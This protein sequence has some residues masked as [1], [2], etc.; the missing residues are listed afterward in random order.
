MK[1]VLVNKFYYPRG[2]DCIHV[3]QLKK[4]LEKNG[5][6]VY[7]FSMDYKQNIKLVED[8][9][10]PTF[11]DFSANSFNSIVKKVIRPFG[12]SE[13]IKKWKYFITHFKPD[14]VHLHNIHSQISPIVAKISIEKKI[15]V[16]WTLHDYKLIC[17]SYLMLRNNRPCD[18]CIT[19]QFSVVKNRCIKNNFAASL[20]GFF[21]IKKWNKRKLQ[22][23]TS[24]FIAP[25]VFLKNQ[26]VKGGFRESSIMHLCNFYPEEKVIPFTKK[27]IDDFILYVG[28]IS[29]EKG[30]ELLLRAMQQFP[31]KKLKI[32]GDGPICSLLKDTYS[33]SRNVEFL[34]FQSWEIIQEQ[35]STARFL[36]VPSEWYENNPLSVIEAL[37]LGTPILGAKIGGIPELISEGKNGFCF[38]PGNLEDLVSGINKM[39]FSSFDRAKISFDAQE[40]FSSERYYEKI[41]QV[42]KQAINRVK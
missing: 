13:V 22:D 36:V 30:V 34:G 25:S 10:W 21:E 19:N 27:K 12:A 17:P 40:K 14:V 2:G 15:P 1:I 28:R 33:D 20:L 16:V 39:F 18:L 38:K 9:Y 23:Y 3:I 31:D 24:T 11:V 41:V 26:M 4:L 5:H 32:I 7:V 35:L 29:K 37:V 6:Q 8:E 42:Y